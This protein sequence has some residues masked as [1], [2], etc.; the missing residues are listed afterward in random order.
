MRLDTI[1]SYLKPTCGVHGDAMNLM[2]SKTPDSY[3]LFLRCDKCLKNA[4]FYGV[5]N[6]TVF[7]A[8]SVDWF[9]KYKTQH[10]YD[11]ICPICKG[12]R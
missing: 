8:A 11:V 10:E 7:A 3:S 9:I 1:Y 4:T 2:Y 5:D 12:K 6:K